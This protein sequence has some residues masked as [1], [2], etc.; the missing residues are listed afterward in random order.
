MIKLLTPS[1]SNCIHLSD[2]IRSIVHCRA[3]MWWFSIRIHKLNGAVVVL[4]HAVP[5]YTHSMETWLSWRSGQ[6]WAKLF[7]SDFSLEPFSF[8]ATGSHHV[9]YQKTDAS[10]HWLNYLNNWQ[11]TTKHSS[12]RQDPL[13]L[14]PWQCTIGHFM[15]IKPIWPFWPMFIVDFFQ[16]PLIPHRARLLASILAVRKSKILILGAMVAQGDPRVHKDEG[17][18]RDFWP[19]WHHGEVGCYWMLIVDDVNC[20]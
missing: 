7:L 4:H 6:K 10:H 13:I 16:A 18:P 14:K 5:C 9:G 15:C 12:T 1:V 3:Q 11:T 2:S 17:K 20:R 8:R 19:P